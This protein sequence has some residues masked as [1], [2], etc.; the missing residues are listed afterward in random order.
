MKTLAA[1]RDRRAKA[2]AVRA[3][4]RP[5]AVG[6]AAHPRNQRAVVE[7]NDQIET[8]RDPAALA[9]DDPDDGG[10]FG[11]DRHGV[12]HGHGAGIGLEVGLED[13]GARPVASPDGADLVRRRRDLPAPVLRC[14]EERGEARGRIEAGQAEPVDRPVPRHQGDGLAIADQRVVFDPC[15]H[16]RG[17]GYESV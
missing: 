9:L 8:H 12:D 14:P 2:Q 10:G 11:R 13:E 7:A 6:G 3:A 1:E 15:G 16:D 5:D 4:D 17:R